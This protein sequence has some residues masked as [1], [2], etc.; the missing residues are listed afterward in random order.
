LDEFIGSSRDI[1]F[2]LK[3]YG[4]K[5][6]GRERSLTPCARLDPGLGSGYEQSK[7]LSNPIVRRGWCEIKKNNFEAS[8]APKQQILPAADSRAP[9]LHPIKP[10]AGLTGAPEARLRTTRDDNS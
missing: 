3:G 6:I 2:A 1:F 7:L 9:L 4:A 8:V 10:E 5:E